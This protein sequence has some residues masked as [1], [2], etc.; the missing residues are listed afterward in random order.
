MSDVKTSHMVQTTMISTSVT[1]AVFHLSGYAERVLGCFILLV[2]T[3][4]WDTR[5]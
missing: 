4:R 5:V 3:I 2:N 1:V